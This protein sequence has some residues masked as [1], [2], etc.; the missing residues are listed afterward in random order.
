MDQSYIGRWIV[1]LDGYHMINK[2]RMGDKN[3][4]ADS[5]SKKTLFYEK[6]EQKQANQAEIKE[7]FSFLNKKLK[8]RFS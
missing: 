5:F 8:R 4:N 2:H 3:Q 6:L 1:R 7:G